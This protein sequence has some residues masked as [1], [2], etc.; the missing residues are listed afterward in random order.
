MLYK[1]GWSSGIDVWILSYCLKYNICFCEI[2]KI[3]IMVKI[4]II[5]VGNGEWK[6][7]INIIVESLIEV[8]VCRSCVD[9]NYL[10]IIVGLCVEREGLF[11]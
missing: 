2:Y 9:R 3:E 4:I 11:F 6:L 5:V 8:L 10:L 7:L 1:S